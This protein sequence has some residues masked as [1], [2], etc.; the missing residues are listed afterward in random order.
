M[1]ERPVIFSGEMIKA[2]LDGRKTMTRRVVKPQP[3]SYGEKDYGSLVNYSWDGYVI[4]NKFVSEKMVEFSPYGQPNDRLWV[5]ENFYRD[6]DTIIYAVDHDKSAPYLRQ[7]KHLSS[8]FMPKS[9]SRI[10]LE[11]ID[12]RVEKLQE[13]NEEDAKKE[14]APLGGYND[15]YGDERNYVEGFENLWN[16]INGKKYPWAI[17]PWV[18]VVEFRRIK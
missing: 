1:K 8:R 2:I 14:G 18:W 16:S 12:I 7:M 17:N 6:E 3:E 11:I 10:T 9:A 13:I 15:Q 5:K 4:T